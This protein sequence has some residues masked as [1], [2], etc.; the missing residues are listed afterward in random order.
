[1]I[2]LVIEKEKKSLTDLIIEKS[3]DIYGFTPNE[4]SDEN[5]KWMRR[6]GYSIKSVRKYKKGMRA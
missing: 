5:L 2:R 4:K 3:V 1:V 6:N